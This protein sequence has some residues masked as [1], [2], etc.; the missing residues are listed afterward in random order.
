MTTMTASAVG[1]DAPLPGA[2]IPSSVAGD[3]RGEGRD[4]A[5]EE[6]ERQEQAADEPGRRAADRVR[7]APRRR[8][9]P[10]AA[11][12]TAR[13]GPAAGAPSGAAG[14]V[15]GRARRTGHALGLRERVP[16]A[17]DRHARSR[18]AAGI[19]LE[20]ATEVLHVAVDRP[21]VRLEAEAVD[22]VEELAAGED[23]ARLA[24]Q[25]REEVELGRR[26]RH[27]AARRRRPDGGA[28]STSRSPATSRSAGRGR[29][30]R[31]GAGPRGPGRRAPSG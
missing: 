11:D 24:R 22:R 18:G 3:P 7:A 19:R 16:D 2:T 28:R 31:R 5:D 8:A 9:V 10:R 23:P 13:V 27:G 25:R 30:L 20:L 1:A 12:P 4:D 17:V 14:A 15:A 26:Q 6:H 29:R 21:L